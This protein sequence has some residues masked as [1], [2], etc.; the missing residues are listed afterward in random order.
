MDIWAGQLPLAQQ[1]PLPL[2]A[3]KDLQ[4]GV[5]VPDYLLSYGK[6]Q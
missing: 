4:Q 3:S 2:M 1:Q 6:E 5:A